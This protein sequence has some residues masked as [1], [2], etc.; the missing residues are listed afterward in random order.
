[1]EVFPPTSVGFVS[2]PNCTCFQHTAMDKDDGFLKFN[3][4]WVVWLK[5]LSKP[6]SDFEIHKLM[7]QM[8]HVPYGTTG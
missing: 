3:M 6:D 5:G 7:H 2:D 4:K 1:M 8:V